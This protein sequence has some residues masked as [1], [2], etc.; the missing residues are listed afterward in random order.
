MARIFGAPVTEPQGNRARTRSPGL[1]PSR[2]S[3]LTVDTI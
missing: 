3:H 2:Y 1:V